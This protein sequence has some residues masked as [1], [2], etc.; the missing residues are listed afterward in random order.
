LNRIIISEKS[1]R[2]E[3]M[4]MMMRR[5][6]RRKRRTMMTMTTTNFMTVVAISKTGTAFNDFNELLLTKVTWNEKRCAS[7]VFWSQKIG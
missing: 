4:M 2:L 6:R 1:L 7:N 5:R 3:K